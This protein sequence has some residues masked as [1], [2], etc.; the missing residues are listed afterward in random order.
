MMFWAFQWCNPFWFF[1]HFHFG[2][3][4]GR[5]DPAGLWCSALTRWHTSQNVTYFVIS[6]LTLTNQHLPL[7][8]WWIFVL[9]GWTEYWVSH[10]SFR[11]RSFNPLFSGTHILSPTSQFHFCLQWDMGLSNSHVLFQLFDFWIN[12]SQFMDMIP[13]YGLCLWCSQISWWDCPEIQ[14]FQIMLGSFGQIFHPCNIC[15]NFS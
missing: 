11:M 13:E 15:I 10:A 9:P 5:I 14:T 3:L 12:G 6:I 4:S 1:S 7:R 8:P 2:I